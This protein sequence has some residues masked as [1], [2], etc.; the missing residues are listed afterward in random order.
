MVHLKVEGSILRPSYTQFF[1][2]TPP[3]KF[4]VMVGAGGWPT[5][6]NCQ[7]QSPWDYRVGG[8]TT[9]T[10]L[11]MIIWVFLAPELVSNVL[12]ELGLI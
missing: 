11:I 10:Y 12:V 7:P 5:E 8:I 3:S 1:C 6:F 9:H 2:G 4:K